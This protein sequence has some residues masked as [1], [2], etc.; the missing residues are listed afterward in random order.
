[1]DA[2]SLEQVLL[3]NAAVSATCMF[4]L[5]LVSLRLRDVS[6]VDSWWALGILAL[7]IATWWQLGASSA[8]AVVLL[9]LC[10]LWSLR[11][12]LYLLWRWFKHGADARYQAIM[13]S[14]EARRGWS[15]AFTAGVQVFLLQGILQFIVALPVQLGQVGDGVGP[16]GILAWIGIALSVLGIGFESVGDWQ[17]VRFKANPANKGKVL[18]T[19]LWRYTRHPNYFGDTCVGWGL[20][21]IAC[22]MPLGIWSLPGPVLLTFLLTRVSGVPMLEHQLQKTRP[23]YAAYIARTSG[24]FPWWPRRDQ[25]K[26]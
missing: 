2:P 15:F 10:A 24:F 25:T 18:D 8:H 4:V 16:L 3:V 13:R 9:G 5:W 12:G 23:E 14:A 17:L 20:F 1:M 7:A 11:L 21:L 26:S 22:E 6:F 19:G